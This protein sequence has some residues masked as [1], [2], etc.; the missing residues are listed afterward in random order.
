M[1][2]LGVHLRVLWHA[3]FSFLKVGVDNSAFLGSLRYVAGNLPYRDISKVRS[4]FT[5]NGWYV[6]WTF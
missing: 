6:L 2:N 1:N 3:K 4:A 5:I